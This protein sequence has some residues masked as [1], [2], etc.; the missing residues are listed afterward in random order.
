[1]GSRS[2]DCRIVVLVSHQGSILGVEVSI[3]RKSYSTQLVVMEDENENQN[4][5][6]PQN[7]GFLIPNIF[8]LTI[9]KVDGGCNL[10]IKV[11]WS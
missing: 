1:M 6:P 4:S 9:P 5:A 10:S 3:S 7:G 11:R 2:C 8:T